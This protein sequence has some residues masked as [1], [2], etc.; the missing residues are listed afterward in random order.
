MGAINTGAVPI[1]KLPLPAHEQQG[2][3]SG[4]SNVRA[5]G[6]HAHHSHAHVRALGSD[7]RRAGE[8]ASGERGEGQHGYLGGAIRSESIDHIGA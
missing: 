3:R 6:N 2:G 7:G 8:V 5:L 1:A 4:S